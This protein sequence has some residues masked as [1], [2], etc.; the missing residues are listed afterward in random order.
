MPKDKTSKIISDI[1]ENE[2]NEITTIAKIKESLHERGFGVLMAVFCLPLILPIPAPPGYT[3]LFSIPLF[4]LSVQMIWGAES[5]WLPK[6]ITSKRIKTQTLRSLTRRAVP[7]LHKIERFLHPRFEFASTKIGERIVG[8]FAF[9]FCLSIALPIPMTNVPP[10][11]GILVMSI[12]LLGKDGVVM[13]IGKVIGIIGLA[14]TGFLLFGIYFGTSELMK[15]V[16][17]DLRP[18]IEE[19]YGPVIE[20]YKDYHENQK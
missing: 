5:P 8:I 12:G 4:I 13:I 14:I 6:W 7:L 10:A 18:H 20:E 2:P 19:T 17:E 16:P 9:I 3:T 11:F 15:N 1:A